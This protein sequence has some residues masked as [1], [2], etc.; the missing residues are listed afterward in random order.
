MASIITVDDV[1]RLD[2]EITEIKA[3]MTEMRADIKQL[4]QIANIG[5]GVLWGLLKL[6]GL[7]V[8]IVGAAAW[9]WDKF[10]K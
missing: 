5:Q 9:L 1:Q 6:G 8:L 7:I 10:G 4:L 3:D 2:R